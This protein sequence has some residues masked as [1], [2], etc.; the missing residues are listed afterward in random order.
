MEVNNSEFLYPEHES[1][2]SS[3]FGEESA[4]E[5]PLTFQLEDVESL[6][7]PSSWGSGTTQLSLEEQRPEQGV[8]KKINKDGSIFKGFKG[9]LRVF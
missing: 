2:W 5:Q 8:I 1:L 7:W 3:F 9:F 4:E 6:D